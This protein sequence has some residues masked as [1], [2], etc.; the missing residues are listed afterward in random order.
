MAMAL[1]ELLPVLQ[2]LNR[3]EKLYVMQF[4]VSKLAQEEGAL[5]QPGVEYS[6]Y[7]PYDADEAADTMLKVLAESKDSQ[8]G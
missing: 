2:E 1:S 7:S 8:Y 3:G 4:L 5:L 6:V